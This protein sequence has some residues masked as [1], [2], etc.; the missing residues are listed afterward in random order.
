MAID[1]W[2][3]LTETILTPALLEDLSS[4][5]AEFLIHGTAVEGK[6]GGI[7]EDLVKLLGTADGRPCTY[8]GGIRDLSDIDRIGELGKGKVNFT[9]GSALDIYG[10]SLPYG[11]VVKKAE[12]FS[13]G[14]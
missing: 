5:C 3:T 14:K 8:A 6:K 10:G 1:R 4:C 12:S 7:D 9:V 13:D 2:Q 11:E